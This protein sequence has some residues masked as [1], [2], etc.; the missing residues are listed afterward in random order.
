MSF[1]ALADPLNFY[2]NTTFFVVIPALNA[3]DASG[4]L[5]DIPG[6]P[7]GNASELDWIPSIAP[8]Q[9]FV[10]VASDSRGTGSGGTI[11]GTTIDG[12]TQSVDMVCAFGVS[13]QYS[14]MQRC[15]FYLLLLSGLFLHNFEWLTGMH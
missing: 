7:T 5:F 15:L 11:D 8:N 13:D 4:T 14:V 10:I 2:R 9:Q 6:S 1:G 3:F 12:I